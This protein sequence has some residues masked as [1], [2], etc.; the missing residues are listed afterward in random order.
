MNNLINL[1][2]EKPARNQEIWLN[3]QDLEIVPDL[4]RKEMYNEI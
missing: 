4:E 2:G 1:V 3:L